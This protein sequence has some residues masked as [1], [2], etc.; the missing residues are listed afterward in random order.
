MLVVFIWRRPKKLPGKFTL[1]F[2]PPPLR[3]QSLGKP[4]FAPLGFNKK[5]G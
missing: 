1:F 3:E 2:S 4:G 5:I